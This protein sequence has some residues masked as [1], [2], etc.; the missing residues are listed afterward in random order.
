[1]FRRVL[2]EFGVRWCPGVRL[3]CEDM[4]DEA[5]G[6]GRKPVDVFE[7]LT[8]MVEQLAAMAWQKMGLQPDFVTGKIEADL[9]QC[10]AAIDATAA[11]VQIIEP[12]LDDDDRRQVQ[13]L[14]RDLRIN[15]V[16]HSR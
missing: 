1:M 3:K 14:V 4:A 8:V 12:K 16:E 9:A 11:V 5:N 6:E 10:K 2:D 13:N 15:Y 7:V